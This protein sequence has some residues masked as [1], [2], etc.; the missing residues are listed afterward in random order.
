VCEI[1]RRGAGDEAQ[2]HRPVLGRFLSADTIVPGSGVLTT[3]PSDG[4]ARD[5]W[6]GAGSSG[7]TNPQDLNR[8]SYVNNNPVT[9]T[10]PTGHC[11]PVP[12]SSCQ[13]FWV[14]GRGLNFRDLQEY[15]AGVV[16]G[17]GAAGKTGAMLLD[18]DTYYDAGR[19]LEAL[20]EN[21][22][23]SLTILQNELVDPVVRGAQLI[24]DD[25][26]KAIDILNV[27]PRAVG[28]ILGGAASSAA[29]SGSI[30]TG[31][32]L[33]FGKNFRIA[34]FGNRTGHPTG[35][36]PHFHR[37]GVDANGITKPG[38]GIGRHRPWDTKSPDTSF[39]DRW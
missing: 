10:D 26:I 34:P 8:Y 9:K 14:T 18:A 31:R 4:T 13:P 29:L 7:P 35:S 20:V 15:S 33:S 17:L 11:I 12:R 21:P 30:I 38:Q 37:R 36:W 23:D 1:Q 25:P 16:E 24:K 3:W 28:R 19:G 32:E 27:N 5:A 2:L 22:K 39:W 6:Q